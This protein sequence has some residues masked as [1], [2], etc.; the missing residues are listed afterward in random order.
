[1]RSAA[2]CLHAC[3]DALQSGLKRKAAEEPDAGQE[4]GRPKKG[5]MLADVLGDLSDESEED[6]AG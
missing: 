2:C 5:G 3:R 1:M 6:E 4:S